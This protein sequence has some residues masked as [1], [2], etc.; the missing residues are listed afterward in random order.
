MILAVKSPSFLEEKDGFPRARE[1]QRRG[2]N[3]REEN[4]DCRVASLLAM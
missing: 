4:W 1:W 2:G 3:D